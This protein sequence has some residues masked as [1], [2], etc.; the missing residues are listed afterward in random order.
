MNIAA[1]IL[2]L[3]SVA[4]M[5]L[6]VPNG[7]HSDNNDGHIASVSVHG[8]HV[9]VC[10]HDH[11]KKPADTPAVENDT[12]KPAPFWMVAGTITTVVTGN[13]ALGQ[14]TLPRLQRPATPRRLIAK[15]RA[16]PIRQRLAELCL[17]I[18]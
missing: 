12:P 18:L 16:P 14:I 1:T 3:V 10:G 15:S 2:C 9:H 17:F 13:T 5:A 8:V 6:P 4:T 11:S 7:W